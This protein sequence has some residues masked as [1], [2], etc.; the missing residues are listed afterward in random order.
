[1]QQPRQSGPDV[2]RQGLIHSFAVHQVVR[3]LEQ[4]AV[5]PRQ[6]LERSAEVS[7]RPSGRSRR[8]EEKASDENAH[9]QPRSGC[10]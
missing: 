9:R 3:S 4:E 1:M 8:K 2:T 10:A 7:P 5:L 6:I